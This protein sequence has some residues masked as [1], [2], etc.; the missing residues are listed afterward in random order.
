[1]LA[2]WD[3]QGG[4][5][6]AMVSPGLGVVMNSIHCVTAFATST[7]HFAPSE[8]QSFCHQSCSSCLE[9]ISPAV[10]LKNVGCAF[11]YLF[12]FTNDTIA[13]RPVV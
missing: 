4:V 10:Q 13:G 12:F 1:M 2:T 11:E 3:F 7:R 9:Y 6:L 5:T 8:L